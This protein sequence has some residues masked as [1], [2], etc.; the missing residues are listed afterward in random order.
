MADKTGTLTDNVMALRMLAVRGRVYG[1]V[2]DTGPHG[3]GVPLAQ[4]PALQADLRAA[5]RLPPPPPP[6]GGGEEGGEGG[7]EEEGGPW[8]EDAGRRHLVQVRLRA[9]GARACGRRA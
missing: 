8:A 1:R 2:D 6:G 7:Y 4:D 3:D 5:A 9:C